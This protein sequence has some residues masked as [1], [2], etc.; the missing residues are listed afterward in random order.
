[1]SYLRSDIYYNSYMDFVTKNFT[2][3]E[4]KLATFFTFIPDKV[5]IFFKS[6]NYTAYLQ[7]LQTEAGLPQT[8]QK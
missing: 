2:N 1:M 3:K 6:V 5:H 4:G 7:S 8:T